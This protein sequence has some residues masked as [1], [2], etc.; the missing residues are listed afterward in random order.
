MLENEFAP[1]VG[2][3]APGSDQRIGCCGDVLASDFDINA[4]ALEC[5]VTITEWH[6]P[7]EE[8]AIERMQE[9]V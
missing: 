8:I 1:G 4:G 7:V 6:P 9:R 2:H 5:L 3:R